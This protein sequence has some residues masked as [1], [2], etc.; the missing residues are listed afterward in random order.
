[1]SDKIVPFRRRPV[2]QP[3]GPQEHL[4]VDEYFAD[5]AHDAQDLGWTRERYMGHAAAAWDLE[6]QQRI[7]K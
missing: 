7:S 2:Q 4:Y 6:R 1:M 5:A 3:P